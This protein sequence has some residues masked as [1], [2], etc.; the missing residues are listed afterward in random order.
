MTEK[1]NLS[2]PSIRKRKMN[3]KLSHPARTNSSK[4][5]HKAEA[6]DG[7][8]AKRQV[9]AAMEAEE[10]GSSVFLRSFG[11][12]DYVVRAGHP[13]SPADVAEQLG[14]PKPTVYR[15]IE[16]LEAQGFVQRQFAARRIVVGPRLVDFAFGV[17]HSSV[18]YAPRRQILN[19]LVAEVGETCNIGTL[20][21]SQI[22]YF[23]RVEAAHWPVRL[24]LTIGSHVPLHCT[25]IGKLFLAFL[26][27]SKRTS[28][29]TQLELASYTGTT[30]TTVAALEAELDRIRQEGLSVNREE[31]LSGVVA[32]AAPVFNARRQLV[33]GIAIQAPASRMPV[34]DAYRYRIPLLEA[35]RR[36]CESF[37]AID[38]NDVP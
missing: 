5:R 21:G 19:S 10:P 11:I 22:V 23:D 6:L 2:Y 27:K 8:R 1:F 38:Q 31:Y 13:V 16:Q 37:L 17:I 33:A 15:M 20:D 35:A 32:L 12:L 29:L 7:D 18:Q 4:S 34:A 14:L 30:I 25:A 9:P 3:D 28:L 24:H 36:L 26:P